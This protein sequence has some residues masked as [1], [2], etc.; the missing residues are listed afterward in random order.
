MSRKNFFWIIAGIINLATA[1]IHIF[2]KQKAYIDPLLNSFEFKNRVVSEMFGAWHMVTVLLLL[3]SFFLLKQGFSDESPR[4]TEGA[5]LV[6]IL[7]FVLTLPFIAVFE[8][9]HV[10]IPYAFLFVLI[11]ILVFMGIYKEKNTK[12]EVPQYREANW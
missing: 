11:G 10:F 1:L 6:G 8:M 9:M 4:S 3:T 5:Y 2:P 12:I 7:F